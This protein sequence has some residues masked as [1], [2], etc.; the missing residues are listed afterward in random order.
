MTDLNMVVDVKA[1]EV[2][3]VDER[4][5]KARLRAGE[6][7]AMRWFAGEQSGTDVWLYRLWGTR[8]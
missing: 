8:A 3:G 7:E 4:S 5:G 6:Q 2:S 1:K